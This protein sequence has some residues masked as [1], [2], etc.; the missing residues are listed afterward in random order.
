MYVRTCLTCVCVF[1]SFSSACFGLCCY[2]IA[3]FFVPVC[4]LIVGSQVNHM[5]ALICWPLRFTLYA[6]LCSHVCAVVL[7]RLFPSLLSDVCFFFL[8]VLAFYNFL[9]TCT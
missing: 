1:S 5:F 2:M 8:T 9:F 3:C 4:V 7:V 6:C